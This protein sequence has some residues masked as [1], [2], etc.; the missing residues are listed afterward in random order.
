[1]RFVIQTLDVV[2][3]TIISFQLNDAMLFLYLIIITVQSIES[4]V[5]VYFKMKVL[6]DHLIENPL[7]VNHLQFRVL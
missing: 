3:L 1:M 7:F 4:S 5:T 2:F 6:E